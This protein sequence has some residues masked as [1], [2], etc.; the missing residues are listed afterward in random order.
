MRR[1]IP[2]NVQQNDLGIESDGSSGFGALKTGADCTLAPGLGLGRMLIRAVSFF[3]PGEIEEAEFPWNVVSARAGAAAGSGEVV[4]ERGG[5]TGG[6]R[7]EIVGF[8]AGESDDS[9]AVILGGKRRTGT[10]GIRDGRTTLAGSRLA[11]S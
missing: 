2:N 1:P 9:T 10:T 6:R 7:R 11:A 3:G 4:G 8:S 5:V